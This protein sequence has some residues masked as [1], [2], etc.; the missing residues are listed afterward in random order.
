[1]FRFNLKL[2]SIFSVLIGFSSA[3]A[4]EFFPF[5]AEG[6]WRT[7]AI[8]CV[9]PNGTKAPQYNVSVDLQ[10]KS[11]KYVATG[12]VSGFSCKVSGPYSE[13]GS[14]VTFTLNNDGGCPLG[15]YI[16]S[17]FSASVSGNKMTARFGKG[18]GD[19]LCPDQGSSVLVYLV[20]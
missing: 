13:N 18:V 9:G 20:K 17:K 8:R 4:T 6:N 5:G 16:G 14:T 1:M 15:D 11:G 2:I 7:S 19:R 3:Q 12:R 10:M